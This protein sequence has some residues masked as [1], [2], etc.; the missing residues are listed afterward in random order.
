MGRYDVGMVKQDFYIEEYDWY[1]RVYYAVK[2]YWAERI[3]NDLYE[4]GCRSS[5]LE[6]AYRSLKA[7]NL[8]TG[9]TYS[10]FG[11]RKTIMV[12]SKTSSPEQFQNSLDHEK[13][14]LCRHISEAFGINPYGEEAQYLSGEVGQKMFP[15]AKKFLC[16]HCRKEMGL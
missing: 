13:G 12:I 10:N 11:K 4:C 1:V 8:N 5:N 16:E 7:G 15:V 2:K 14:H 9:L 6:R 3:A